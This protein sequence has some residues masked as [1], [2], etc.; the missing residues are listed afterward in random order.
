MIHANRLRASRWSWIRIASCELFGTASA[1]VTHSTAPESLKHPLYSHT[2]KGCSTFVQRFQSSSHVTAPDTA[3][4]PP[5]QQDFQVLKSRLLDSAL[6]LVPQYGWSGETLDHA[7]ADLDLSPALGGAATPFDLVEHFSHKCNLKLE[8][9]LYESKEDLSKM[10]VHDRLHFGIKRRLEMTAQ[11]A[12]TWPQALNILAQHPTESLKLLAELTDII[13]RAAGDDAKD[14]EWYSKRAMLGGVY[15]ATELYLLTDG[16]TE[17]QESWEALHRRLD[18][19][20]GSED[21]EE[22]EEEEVDKEAGQ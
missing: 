2:S 18:E 13:W 6:E 16:S 17:C 4:S 3:K 9:E 21:E 7:A 1:T 5:Q 12:D 22:E 20:F 11:H 15:V 10:S 14:F 8:D 19:V